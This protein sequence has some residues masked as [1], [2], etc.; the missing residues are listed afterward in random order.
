MQLIGLAR[1]GHDASLRYT[2]DG[3]PVANLS[4]AFNYGLRDQQGNRPTQWIEASLWGDRA[5]KLKDY[6]TKGTLIMV[7]LDDPHIESYDKRDG[8]Q[9]VKMV[10]RV[11]AIEFTG[12]AAD[13]KPNDAPAAPARSAAAQKPST[14]GIQEMQDDIPF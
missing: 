2:A 8:T 13:A 6:L 7:S 12:R 9:G 11:N 3:K 14:G 1:L 10:A 5:E 4:L